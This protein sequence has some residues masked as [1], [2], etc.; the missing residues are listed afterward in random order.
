MMGAFTD[1]LAS[2]LDDE[3]GQPKRW[4]F[5]AYDQLS[6]ELEPMISRKQKLA[7]GR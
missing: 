5:V 3:R 7:T 6:A 2:A 4:L 1:A